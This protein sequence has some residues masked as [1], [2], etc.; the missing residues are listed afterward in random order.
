MRHVVLREGRPRVAAMWSR[1]DRFVAASLTRY[2]PRQ[3]VQA[4]KGRLGGEFRTI[5]SGLPPRQDLMKGLMSLG[6]VTSGEKSMESEMSVDELVSRVDPEVDRIDGLITVTARA[7]DVLAL[8]T[9]HEKLSVVREELVSLGVP[10]EVLEVQ[11][12][13][14]VVTAYPVTD[15]RLQ[16]W[17]EEAEE[18]GDSHVGV[19]VEGP[20]LG[21]TARGVGKIVL[22][23]IIGYV[24]LSALAFIL[25]AVYDRLAG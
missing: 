1:R 13:G 24:V 8:V 4:L 9:S 6:L 11:A 16:R 14:D 3:I 12:I 10:E 17:L 20:R 2:Q 23:L 21:M 5:R 19:T 22:I 15:E 25:M 7:E 18:A